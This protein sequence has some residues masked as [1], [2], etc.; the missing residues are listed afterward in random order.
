MK[1]DQLESA[2]VSLTV[3]GVHSQAILVS[4][5]WFKKQQKKNECG[6]PVTI[7]EHDLFDE[8]N[9]LPVD[10]ILCRTITLVDKLNDTIGNVLFVYPY[11]Y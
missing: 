4:L 2:N 11:E 7:L 5:S 6:K 9:F 8:C 3:D 1:P 10:K